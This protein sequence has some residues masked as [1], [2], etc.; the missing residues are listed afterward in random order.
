MK[1]LKPPKID[2]SKRDFKN[3][4]EREFKDE[5][6]DKID[7]NNICK[8][9][10]R[11]PD[12]SFIDFYETLNHQLDEYPLYKMVTRKVLELL[13]KPWITAEILSKCKRR[14]E[15]LKDIAKETDQGEINKLR[16]EY[17]KLRNEITLDKRNGKKGYFISYFERNKR[18]SSDIWKGIRLLVNT[19]TPKSSNIKL[20]DDQ[21]NLIS[22]PT[23]IANI[24]NNHFSTV[25]TK[26]DSK[27][28][29]VPGSYKTYLTKKDINNKPFLNPSYSFFLSPTVPPE[30]AKIIDS[31]DLKKSTGPMSLPPFI[32]KTY[33]DFF[34]FWLCQLVNLSFEVGIFPDMLKCARIT[35]IHKKESKLNYLNYRPISLLSVFSKIFEKLIYLRIYSFLTKNNLISNKQFGFRS[36]YSTNHAL[37]SITERIKSLLDDTQFV[38]GIFIDLEKA[39]DTVN[40]DILCNKLNYYG[41]RGNVNKLIQSYLTN[42][43]QTVSINGQDSETRDVACGVPQGSSLGPLLFLIY[44]NDFRFCLSQTETGHFADDTYILFGNKKLKTIETV[45][46]TELKRVSSWLHLNRLSLNEGKT[47]LIIFHSKRNFPQT[48][49]SIKLNGIKL[50]PVNSVK[51]LGMY[52]DKH[53]SWDTHIFH[54]SQKLSRADGILSKLRHNAPRHVCLSVYYALFYSHLIYGCNIWGI[55]TDENLD[56]IVKLQKKCVRTITFSNYDSHANPLFIDLKIL[57][58]HDVIKLQ[59]LKLAYEYCNNLIP[60]DLRTFFK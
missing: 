36:G 30:V 21:N 20:M 47:E 18:K 1:E 33:K 51:Y 25:G 44:I 6:I 16:S 41:L 43:K 26:V 23:K 50:T 39:F 28:P 55:T 11:D 9:D 31:L 29:H 59:L 8:I 53:L 10:R 38:C 35:P 19:K 24:F 5:V 42:R 46:N 2:I 56:K 3:F 49:F 40:H 13:Q 7:W 17:K 27:I 15:K 37:V 57:K 4:N 48:E 34:S 32:L 60:H 54:L 22:D 52:I 58:V 14:D 12:L 45:M